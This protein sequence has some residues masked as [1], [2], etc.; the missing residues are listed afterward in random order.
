[1]HSCFRFV[2][3]LF[4]IVA[5]PSVAKATGNAPDSAVAKFE[6][7]SVFQFY[8]T[9][10]GTHAFS[11]THSISGSMAAFLA[12]NT[13]ELD[14]VWN[15]ALGEFK[16]SPSLGTT[17]GPKS[18]NFVADK[19]LKLFR[20]ITPSF[21]AYYRGTLFEAESYNKIWFPVQEDW[22]TA[23]GIAEVR[24]WGVIKWNEL[25]IGPHAAVFFTKDPGTSYYVSHLWV[26]AHLLARFGRATLHAVVGYDPIEVVWLGG[27]KPAAP[28]FKGTATYDF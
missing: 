15:F 24:L 4:L 25:G 12:V 5:L 6:I 1:M 23:I 9:F 16:L 7:D 21:K 18:W 27:P 13:L 26:G 28:Y 11:A 22:S 8:T 17:F 14:V 20:D 10:T 2:V 19:S 3:M